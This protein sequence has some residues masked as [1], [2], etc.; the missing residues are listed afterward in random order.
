MDMRTSLVSI[1]GLYEVGGLVI[2]VDTAT[3]SATAQKIESGAVVSD[4]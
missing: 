1:R 2:L 4:T 3:L